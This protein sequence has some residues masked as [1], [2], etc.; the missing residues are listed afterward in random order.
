MHTWL[1]SP[2]GRG[3]GRDCTEG[4]GGAWRAE[5]GSLHGEG[6]AALTVGG[7]LEEV[8]FSLCWWF[9]MA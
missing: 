2:L 8:G 3:Q 7:L 5:W 4:T 1:T 9:G 6:G